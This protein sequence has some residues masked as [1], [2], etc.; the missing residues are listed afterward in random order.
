M[1][2]EQAKCVNCG[3]HL[4]I[5]N[6]QKSALCPSC[7]TSYLISDNLLSERNK[8]SETDFVIVNGELLEYKG[9]SKE[10]VIPN[11]VTVIGESA[12]LGEDII[13]VSIPNSVVKIKDYAFK[14]C[15][16]LN[17]IRIP[18]SI[19][20]I[21]STA[22]QGD[23]NISII[24]PDT[25]KN[26]HLL[27]MHIVA[28]SENVE[29]LLGISDSSRLYGTLFYYYCGR[30]MSGNYMFCERE[31]FHSAHTRRS[32]VFDE[33]EIA[34]LDIVKM[35]NEL[36]LLFDRSG[37]PRNIINTIEVPYYGNKTKIINRGNARNRMVQILEIPLNDEE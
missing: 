17:K 35:Y 14:D 3:A 2:F 34:A 36:A 19:N 22:F 9:F 30:D 16:A 37:I 27:K 7:G 31:L 4:I 28:H 10:V 12:F 6:I 21:D 11:H 1:T 29:T 20:E 23:N 26:K 8:H 33:F 25:W 15:H 5:D 32:S 24:W 18:S 13:S